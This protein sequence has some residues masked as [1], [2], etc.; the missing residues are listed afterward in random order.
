MITGNY[1]LTGVRME[2][3]LTAQEAKNG[4]FF[5]ESADAAYGG[6]HRDVKLYPNDS[7]YQR[8]KW[9]VSIEMPKNVVTAAV[10][11]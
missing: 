3:S 11:G 7:P 4:L 6:I 10:R 9:A 2:H 5:Y 1:F 8:Q